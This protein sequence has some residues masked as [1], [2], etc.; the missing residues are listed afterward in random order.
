MRLK[1]T[2]SGRLSLRWHYPGSGWRVRD[3]RSR[4]QPGYPSSPS[5]DM[6]LLTNHSIPPA[7]IWR[8]IAL[9]EFAT[10]IVAGYI[11]KIP[12]RG[13]FLDGQFADS[14]LAGGFEE[15][16]CGGSS[17]VQRLGIAV[18]GNRDRAARC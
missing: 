3:E 13:L 5:A 1:L 18:H 7:R 6:R 11:R 17:N 14:A 4:S 12:L 10:L 16:N 8:N 15:Y 2:V 9:R